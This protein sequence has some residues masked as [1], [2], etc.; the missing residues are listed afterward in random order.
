MHAEKENIRK[1]QNSVYIGYF[2]GLGNTDG[3][4]IL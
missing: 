3:I 1:K 4:Y 2:T